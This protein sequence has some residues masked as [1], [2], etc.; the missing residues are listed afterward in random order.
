MTNSNEDR[1]ITN[2]F[3]AFV[4]S[5]TQ[6]LNQYSQAIITTD[7]TGRRDLPNTFAN[8]VYRHSEKDGL[9]FSFLYSL[10]STVLDL[11]FMELEEDHTHLL[12][13][14]SGPSPYLKDKYMKEF[15]LI[16]RL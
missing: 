7:D 8:T 13:K 1:N 14:T 15:N 6:P 4:N 12:G 16:E 11:A 5:V 2:H 3:S 9:T 10:I